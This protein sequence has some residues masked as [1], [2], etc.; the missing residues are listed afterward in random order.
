MNLNERIEEQ[1]MDETLRG[2]EAFG[3]AAEQCGAEIRQAM[4]EFLNK[5]TNDD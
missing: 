3:K 1:W 2:I 4:D 5:E